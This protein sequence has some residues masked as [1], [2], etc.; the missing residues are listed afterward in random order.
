MTTYTHSMYSKNISDPAGF[1]DIFFCWFNKHVTLEFIHV[2]TA[3]VNNCDWIAFSWIRNLLLSVYS[4]PKKRWIFFLFYR[5]PTWSWWCYECYH[6]I[7]IELIK[8]SGFLALQ[9]FKQ[10]FYWRIRIFHSCHCNLSVQCL[11]FSNVYSFCNEFF[12]FIE[13]LFIRVLN[14]SEFLIV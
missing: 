14:V 1:N 3:L 7:N 4:F 2:H 13:L 10:L 12:L 9:V 5:I 8:F 11:V 6:A